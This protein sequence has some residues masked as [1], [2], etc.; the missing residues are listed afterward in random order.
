MTFKFSL[1]KVL[2]IRFKKKKAATLSTKISRVVSSLLVNI[3]Y[4]KSHALDLYFPIAQCPILTTLYCT[5][6]TILTILYY[7]IL[8][9]LYYTY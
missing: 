2:R 8:T 1:R 9:I 5:N 7:T 4:L 3:V 6:Y